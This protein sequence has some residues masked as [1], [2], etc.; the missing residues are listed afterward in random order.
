[1]RL[2]EWMS[3][4]A[5]NPRDL[6]PKL[7]QGPQDFWGGL[8]LV[9]VALFFFWASSDLAGMRGFSFGPG[10]APRLSAGLLLALGLGVA[11]SG[12]IAKGSPLQHFAFRGPFFVTISI[13][14]F[15]LTIRPLGL[16]LTCFIS[17][18]VAGLGT[19]ETRW[20]ETT[21]VGIVITAFCSVLFP[22]G[23]GLPFQLWPSFIQ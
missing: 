23:L 6:P 4:N 19:P 21:I 16:V 11:A 22:Y 7:I 3:D 10:T 13:L 12:L 17:F 8:A 9:A 5:A 18:M 15:A 1:M 20:I 2:G 14:V